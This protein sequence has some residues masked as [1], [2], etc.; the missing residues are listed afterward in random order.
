MPDGPVGTREWRV[1]RA[2]HWRY[3]TGL[4]NKEIGEKLGVSPEQVSRYLHEPPGDE[5]REQIKEQEITTRRVAYEEL[6]WQ[7]QESG[8]RARTA[9][10]PNPVW[11]DDGDVDVAHITDGDG[12]VVDLKPIPDG[13]EMGPDEKQRYYGRMESREIIELLADI[14][15]A[16]E[17]D[18][19]EVG[20]ADGAPLVVIDDG[21]DE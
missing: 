9:T 12:Q 13:Y 16:A 18:Q 2:I 3:C 4:S 6:M 17:P 10:A 11:P 1:E 15:G 20:G 19:Y 21:D 14:T 8:A 5:V 7:L